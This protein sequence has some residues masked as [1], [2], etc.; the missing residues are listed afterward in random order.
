VEDET[1]E[2]Q[3]KLDFLV[4]APEARAVT[5]QHARVEI[6]SRKALTEVMELARTNLYPQS[7]R[8]SDRVADKL[9][10]IYGIDENSECWGEFVEGCAREFANEYKQLHPLSEGRAEPISAARERQTGLRVTSRPLD[11]DFPDEHR[12]L[13]ALDLSLQQAGPDEPWPV[14]FDLVCQPA[15][16]VE[17]GFQFG[18]KR[19]RLEIDPGA[20]EIS[21]RTNERLGGDRP[22]IFPRDHPT[23]TI[24]V[25]I[26]NAKGRRP[27][28][29]VSSDH[30]PIG[31]FRLDDEHVLCRVGGIAPEDEVTAVFKVLIADLEPV[32]LD[33]DDEDDDGDPDP[34]SFVRE[35]GKPLSLAKQKIIRR[36]L[37][38]EEVGSPSDGWVIVASDGRR[39]EEDKADDQ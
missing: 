19:G 30:G 37:V 14:S 36:M 3:E 11:V 33:D 13:A 29:T 16:A 39:F 1:P 2:L 24:T 32:G 9:R 26:A 21:P 28:W 20:A 12:G 6:T 4:S 8:L 5:K 34:Y 15:P 27:A 31:I 25:D 18:V 10:Q 7:G 22:A 17:R 23:R 35:D 38:K